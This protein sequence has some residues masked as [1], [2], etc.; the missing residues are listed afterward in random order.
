MRKKLDPSG[1]TEHFD[2]IINGYASV[3]DEQSPALARKF[4]ADVGLYGYTKM[5]GEMSEYLK[6][7]KR[8]NKRL[9]SKVHLK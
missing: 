8:R 4:R 9:L 7:E 5:Q 6:V 2:T 1:L 3:F